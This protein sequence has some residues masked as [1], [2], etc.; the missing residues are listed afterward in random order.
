[1]NRT[2]I[3]SN[4]VFTCLMVTLISPANGRIDKLKVLE[5]HQKWIETN[6]TEGKRAILRNA[7]LSGAF[8]TGANLSGAILSGADLSKSELSG[9]DLSKA[10]LYKADSAESI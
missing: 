1:M 8:L 3:I 6:R 7:D 2:A 10:N 5:D 9:A 4:I